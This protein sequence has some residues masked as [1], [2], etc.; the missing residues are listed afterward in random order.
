[1]LHL[2][3]CWLLA[4]LSTLRPSEDANG[5]KDGAVSSPRTAHRPDEAERF[6]DRGDAPLGPALT[7]AG[8]VFEGD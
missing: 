6:Y 7:G 8:G 2:I 5:E 1:M 3:S 4:A